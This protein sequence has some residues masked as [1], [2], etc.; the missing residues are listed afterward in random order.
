MN[1]EH[2][3]A[4]GKNT[5]SVAHAVSGC[6]EMWRLCR[7]P[8]KHMCCGLFLIPFD[9]CVGSAWRCGQIL[10]FEC[11]AKANNGYNGWGVA[12][13]PLTL[14]GACF[15]IMVPGTLSQQRCRASPCSPPPN[16][17]NN[18]VEWKKCS[19]SHRLNKSL[20]GQVQV[21]TANEKQS[22]ARCFVFFLW[23][24]IFLRM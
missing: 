11:S 13:T 12:L 8:I 24:N 3:R 21:K 20:W 23:T 2:T 17:D 10:D 1:K 7:D 4:E 22:E 5:L 6:E 18:K 9:K 16:R 19:C 14:S 15:W